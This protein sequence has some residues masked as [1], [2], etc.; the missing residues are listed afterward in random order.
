MG[1]FKNNT[2]F[3]QRK[4]SKKLYILSFKQQLIVYFVIRNKKIGTLIPRHIL[5]NSDRKQLFIYLQ[6][7]KN[8][9]SSSTHE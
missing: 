4:N 3:V 8:N 1:I 6:K 5:N 9:M 7:M 2:R